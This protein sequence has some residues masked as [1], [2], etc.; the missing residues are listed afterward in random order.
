MDGF[1]NAR[2]AGTK[3]VLPKPSLSPFFRRIVDKLSTSK[4]P[5]WTTIGRHILSC[6]DFQGQGAVERELKRLGR[7][8]RRASRE[9]SGRCAL[10]IVPPE[11]RKAPVVF[12]LFPETLRRGSRDRAAQ[13]AWEVLSESGRDECCVL[14]KSV[15]DWRNP[16][17]AVLLARS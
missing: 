12:Y 16:Y 3:R 1:Y 14:V 4:P 7:T 15:K 5:R 17:E 13:V 8:V 10:V 9:G 6:V 11:V 2:D